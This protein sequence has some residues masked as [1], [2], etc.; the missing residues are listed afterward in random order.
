M[1][2][3]KIEAVRW[4]VA[5]NTVLILMKV[6]VTLMTGSLAVLATLVDSAFDMLGTAFAYIGIKKASEPADLEHLYGHGKV[7]SLA[8]LAQMALIGITAILLISEAVKRIIAPVH[9]DVAIYDIAVMGITILIDLRMSS[10]LRKKS[11]D[12]GSVALEASA[13]NYTSDVWQNSAVLLGLVFMQMDVAI[14]DPIAAIIIALFMLRIVRSV[15]GKAMGELLD[16]SPDKEIIKEIADAILA[17][18]EV[19]S[20]HHLRARMVEGKALVDV[21][22]QL[23][24][25][26]TLLRAHK[27]S[28]KVRETVLKK[29][30]SVGDMFIHIE[31]EGDTEP[32]EKITPFEF[33]HGKRQRR[34]KKKR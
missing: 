21:H 2:E 33:T 28:H 12:T 27:I 25:N 16:I 22:L 7:E 29:V 26:I 14:A 24:P 13:A 4:V 15:G 20:F 19:K 32:G 11:S 18:R 34:E 1:S 3:Q 17:V 8:G 30:P 5:A 23:V 31:P 9:L 6:L 10:Y